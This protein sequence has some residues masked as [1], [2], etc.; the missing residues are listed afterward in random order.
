MSCGCGNVSGDCHCGGGISSV[1]NNTGCCETPCAACP[2]STV[3]CE[4]LPSALDNFTRSFFGSVTKTEI[5]GVVTWILPCN[6]DI[7][8]TNNPRGDNEGLACYFLRLFKDGIVG[9]TGP[10]GNTGSAGTNGN[11]AYAV[12][13]SAITTPTPA[14][15]NTTFNII[16]NPLI[17]EGLSIFIP[18]A[19]WLTVTTAT[20]NET[21]FAT[22]IQQVS[23]PLATIPAGTLVLPTG[24]R[25]ITITGSQGP[26]GVTGPQGGQGATGATG[27]TGAV[28][29]VGP[30]GAIVT[31]ANTLVEVTGG[32]DYTLTAAYAKVDFGATDLE[33][34]LAAAG[35]YLVTYQITGV[36]ATGTVRQWATK[37]FNATTALDIPS[38][39][40]LF[41]ITNDPAS[42]SFNS[43]T[44]VTTAT[45]N[46]LIQIYAKSDNAII[47]QQIQQLDSRLIYVR[48]A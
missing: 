37:L 39:E 19:G 14:H 1:N 27:A 3:D 28:G 22:L 25:G 5:N 16:P 11:N 23:S 46:N 32:A 21:I 38:S 26:V 41:V 6:L 43:T 2:T 13:T 29:A 18:G 31:N 34:T 20:N 9:L 15:P 47:T 4:T 44:L 40:S 17:Q 30:A 45:V 8:L 48:L 42:R 35:T 12:M 36:Q 7:G 33:I 10:S 24:P